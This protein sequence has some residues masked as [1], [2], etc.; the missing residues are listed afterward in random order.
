MSRGVTCAQ[1]FG[2]TLPG[3]GKNHAVLG[4]QDVAGMETPYALRTVGSVACRGGGRVG[5]AFV[6]RGGVQGEDAPGTGT[7]G[8][9]GRG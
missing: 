2:Q 1:E 8:G 6:R 3:R 9:P 7:E 5:E 4:P